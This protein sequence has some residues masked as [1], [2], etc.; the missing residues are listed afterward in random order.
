MT[1]IPAEVTRRIARELCRTPRA[2]VYG[3]LGTCQTEFGP[4]ASWLIEALNVVSGHF[5][6][7]GGVMF[8]LAAADVATLARLLLPRQHGRFRSRVR[9]LPEFLDALPSAA[10]AEEMETPGPG[11]IRG[12]ISF[13]GDPV[14]STPN[15]PRVGRAIEQLDYVVSIDFYMNETCR[16]AHLVLPPTHIFESGN[17]ELVLGAFAVRPFA[18]YSPP[19]LPLPA[20]ARDDWEILSELAARIVGP[21]H[22]WLGEWVRRRGARAPE[23]VID[24]LLRTGR[25]GLRLKDLSQHPHGK[26]LGPLVPAMQERVHTEDRRVHL[27]PAVFLAELPRLERWVDAPPAPLVLIGRRHLRSNNSW[28]HNLRPLVK[29]PSRAQLLMHPLDATAR[30]VVA[31][32]R[33]RVRSSAGEVDVDVEVTDSVRPGVV[34]MPHGFGHEAG[35]LRLAANLGPSVNAITDDQT[36]EPV[37]GNSILSGVPVKVEPVPT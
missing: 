3:R 27:A 24:L 37:L 36:V 13:A 25:H 29:G 8:P 28:M 4:L 30:G 2:A 10:M 23:A 17:Y 6:R 14:L 22:P 21:N 32:S 12:L 1:G 7:E 26:D 5:D 19:I 35:G 16:R 20:G 11:Q 34:S 33:V 31:R 9:G 18:R 15:G